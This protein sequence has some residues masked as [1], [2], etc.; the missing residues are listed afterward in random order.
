MGELINGKT[1]EQIKAAIRYCEN[2]SCDD[3]PYADVLGCGDAIQ[4][5][6]LALIERLEAAQPRLSSVK[7]R[8]PE[9]T[10]VY[11]IHMVHRYNKNDGYRCMDVRLFFKDEFAPWQGVPDI[12]E[13]THWMPLPEPPKEG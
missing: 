12:Y 1:P 8:L 10:N 9:E 13:V 11:L 6:A 2:W 4:R 7:E 3:C 5:D